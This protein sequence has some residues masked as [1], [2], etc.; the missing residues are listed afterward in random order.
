MEGGMNSERDLH[1]VGERDRDTDTDRQR[2]PNRY[3]R[4]GV[5][6]EE[7]HWDTFRRESMSTSN[8]KE[9]G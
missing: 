9:E 1:L 3:P 5:C 2:A 7:N 4:A 6:R 8:R